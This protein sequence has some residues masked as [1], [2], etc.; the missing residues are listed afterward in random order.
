M[1]WFHIGLHRTATT[2]RETVFFPSVP[3]V[4]LVGSK[5]AAGTIDFVYKKTI[6][7]DIESSIAQLSTYDKD[8]K[9][10]VLSHG[11]LSMEPWTAALPNYL[12]RLRTLAPNSKI[13]LIL[14][15]PVDW[16]F[17]VYALAIQKRRF[18]SL[19]DFTGWN[20][21]D[22]FYPYGLTD[23]KCMLNIE[24]L[25]F[26][27]IIKNWENSFSPE[28]INILFFENFLMDPKS[29]L[30]NL[31]DIIGANQTVTVNAERRINQSSSAKTI[32]SGI[33]CADIIEKALQDLAGPQF[34]KRAS[35]R[36]ARTIIDNQFSL[37]LR[38]I[39]NRREKIYLA[40]EDRFS[41]ERLKISKSIPDCPWTL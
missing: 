25:S 36:V 23:R 27:K 9:I 3:D 26:V 15:N 8:N 40:L 35:R 13:L 2:F 5:T 20:G 22:F 24:N 12:Y 6:S 38:A 1:I 19:E 31:L 14:R 28:N 39:Q 33:Y 30:L 32:D 16:I 34:A 29:F 7:K 11:G 4:N 41:D 17:S 18:I 21:K 37:P 10:H